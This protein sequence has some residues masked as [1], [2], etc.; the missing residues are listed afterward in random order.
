M[1]PKQVIGKTPSIFRKGH[2]D[3]QPIANMPSHF[4]LALFL[5]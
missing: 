4:L 5:A 2:L 3:R 1:E